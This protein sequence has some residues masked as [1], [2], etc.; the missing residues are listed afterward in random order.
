[1]INTDRR[2]GRHMTAVNNGTGTRSQQSKGRKGKNPQSLVNDSFQ[3]HE[4]CGRITRNLIA[5]RKLRANLLSLARLS[6]F[7]SKKY[8]RLVRHAAVALDPATI[9]FIACCRSSG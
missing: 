7:L 1:M 6:L 4:V 3:V 9:S 5:K 2:A 8:P